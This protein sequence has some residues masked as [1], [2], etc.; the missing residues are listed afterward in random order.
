MIRAI[1]KRGDANA[2]VLTTPAIHTVVLGAD[3]RVLPDTAKLV[4]DLFETLAATPNGIGLA[5][6]QIGVSSQVF[7]V[8][9][10]GLTEA[11]IN[12]TIRRVSARTANAYEGCLSLPNVHVKVT[13]PDIVWL[14]YTDAT[15]QRHENAKFR[16]LEARVIQHEFDHLQGKLIA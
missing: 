1:V 13:R 10:R 7:V 8:K 14:D 5:A 2:A 6:P 16:K 11:F 4:A 9:L 12:P 3:L 15:G